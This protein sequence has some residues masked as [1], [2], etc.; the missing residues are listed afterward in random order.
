MSSLA[1]IGTEGHVRGG[2]GRTAPVQNGSS[3]ARHRSGEGIRVWLSARELKRAQVV[4]CRVRHGARHAGLLFP[5]AS[6]PRVAVRH[7]AALL[8]Q[9]IFV[10][11][12]VRLATRTVGVIWD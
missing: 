7:G 3:S 1:G 11:T 8:L 4:L 2:L 9:A 10:D 5:P 6:L 12:A